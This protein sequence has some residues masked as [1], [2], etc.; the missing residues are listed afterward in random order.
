M[1]HPSIVKIYETIETNN[2][3]NIIMEYIPGPCLSLYLRSFPNNRLP[4]KEGKRIFK[5]L[6]EALK[7]LHSKCIAHRD[8]KLENIL[9]DDKNNIKLIDFGFSTCIPNEQKTKMFCGTPSY[10]S[11]EIVQKLEYSGPPADIWAA[12]VLLFAYICGLFLKNKNAFIKKC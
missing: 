4:E 7:Y 8:I 9:I 5:Q 6:L 10:M 12:G 1:S 3:I 11:P 2:H